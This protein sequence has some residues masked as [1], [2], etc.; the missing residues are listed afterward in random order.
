MDRRVSESG[1]PLAWGV[2]FAV[3]LALRVAMAQEAGVAPQAAVVSAPPDASG[4]VEIDVPGGEVVVLGRRDENIQRATTQVVTVLSTEDIARTG[5]GDIAGSL[6][7][8]TGLSV[9]G[10]GFVYVRGLGDR[11]SLALLN[12]SPLPSPEPMRRA[13]PLDLFPTDVVASSLVQKTY[14]ANFTGEFGGGVIN[15]TTLAVPKAPFLNFSVGG[16]GDG[17]TTDKLGYDY[18]GSRTDWSGYDNGNRDIPPALASFFASGQRI[19]AGGVDSGAIASEFAN[20][21]NVLVQSIDGLPP[22]YSTSVTGGNSWAVG[23]GDL[24]LIA[25]AGFSNKWRTRENLEQTPGSPDLSSTNKDYR[26]VST[27]NRLVAN[28][29]FGLGY[30]FGDGNRLRWTNLYVHD[31]LKRT[32]LSEGRWN[33]TYTDFEF[34]EQSTGWYERELLGTQL[35]GSLRFEP[36]TID[37]RASYSKSS[38]EAPFELGIG[39]ARTNVAADPYGAFFVNRLS[40]QNRNFADIAFSDLSEDLKSFGFDATWPVRS[41]LVLSAGYDY[42]KTERDSS[43]REFQIRAPSTFPASIGMLRPDYLL[44]SAVIDYYDIGLIETTE[45]DPAFAASLAA[46]GAYAQIQVELFPGLE[47]S[48]GARFE[49]AEQDVRPVQVFST[50][51]NSG[52]S[53]RIENDYVLPA[54]T[55]TYKFRDTMQVRLNASKT[56][57]RPQFRELMFQRYYD[58]EANREYLGNPLLGDSEFFNAEARFEWYFAPEQRLSVAGFYKKIDSPIEA[59]VSYPE[60]DSPVISFAN[61]PEAQLYGVEAEF[62]K[63]FPLHELSDAAFLA[64]R[65]AVLIGNYSYTTSSINVGAGDTVQVYGSVITSRPASDYFVDGGQLT[66]QSDHLV[67]LQLGLE[68]E[69]KLSQQTV[70][71][72]YASDRVTSRGGG[73][74]PDIYE[75][76]GAQR[77]L[78]RAPGP[79]NVRSGPGAQVRGAE[80]LPAR[81]QGV[82]AQRRQHDLLQPLRPG[83]ALRRLDQRELLISG[84]LSPDSGSDTAAGSSSDTGRS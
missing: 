7:R 22:G 42:S 78:R 50:L 81:L 18:Y 35:N 74:W 17:E 41:G 16:S 28:A 29:L 51:T 59:Y 43:R 58:P 40:G 27:E 57:A 75:S 26:N 34:R 2:V 25:T 54:A 52:A 10:G 79:D 4:D 45:T 76:P 23:D 83:D 24:G 84:F 63:Y 13:V 65:R 73:S 38:R 60:G 67:N 72:S 21:R 55:L 48:T 66:G 9:V 53:T 56:I 71:L 70:L 1:R 11:Y 49:K 61:A 80:H 46:Q 44:G 37:A 31:T 15:L 69:D 62:Q 64:N 3:A 47:L 19:S 36:L 82:P 20:S 77:G 39:Y 30:E 68:S 5:D 32:S 14:S 12:G 33:V 8:V 6:G